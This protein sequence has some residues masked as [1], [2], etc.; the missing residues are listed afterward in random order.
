MTEIHELMSTL[1]MGNPGAIS[2]LGKINETGRLSANIILTLIELSITGSVIWKLHKDI[3]GQDIKK[4]ISLID[5]LSDAEKPNNI[6]FFCQRSYCDV[7]VI[8]YLG[9]NN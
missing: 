9:V 6:K 8:N 3:C 1:T 7:N 2:V 5:F 4:T